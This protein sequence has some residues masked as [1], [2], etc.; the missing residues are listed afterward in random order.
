MP[1]RPRTLLG[2]PPLKRR[3]G[4]ASTGGRLGDGAAALGVDGALMPDEAATL[5]AGRARM[6]ARGGGRSGTGAGG[7]RPQPQSQSS[8]TEQQPRARLTPQ[9]C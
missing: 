2:P 5:S 6:A 4:P 8:K 7:V 9:K 1:R 3:R